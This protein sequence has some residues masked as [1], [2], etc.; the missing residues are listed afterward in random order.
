M[1]CIVD[2]YIN[3]QKGDGLYLNS[4]MS[5]HNHKGSKQEITFTQQLHQE[6]QEN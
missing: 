6:E 4:G 5:K 1:F 2:T 3:E